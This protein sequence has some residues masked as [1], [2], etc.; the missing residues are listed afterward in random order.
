MGLFARDPATLLRCCFED[1]EVALEMLVELEDGSHVAAPVAV[2]RG[3]PD[4]QNGLVE[5]PL[6]AFHDELQKKS[7]PVE[8]TLRTRRRGKLTIQKIC[9]QRENNLEIIGTREML[10]QSCF[11]IIAT[12]Q[13]GE[14][15]GQIRSLP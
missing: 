7:R 3:A 1:G 12:E 10:M 8:Q 11:V 15:Q 2:V 5:V 9:E 13:D 4:G 14:Q 6:V